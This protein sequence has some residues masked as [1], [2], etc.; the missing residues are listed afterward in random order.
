MP[1]TQHIFFLFLHHIITHFFFLLRK[2]LIAAGQQQG[3]Q[4]H[5]SVY[6]MLCTCMFCI[7]TLTP[8]QYNFPL[9][10][11]S[12]FVFFFIDFGPFQYNFSLF[13]IRIFTIIS[14]SHILLLHFF[15]I[16]ENEYYDTCTKFCIIKFIKDRNNCVKC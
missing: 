13:N 15:R 12:I 3:K 2:S 9:F 4:F 7:K 5:C 16:F 11:H 10:N 8:T 14:Y 1:Y 6:P